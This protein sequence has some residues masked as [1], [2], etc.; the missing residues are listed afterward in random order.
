MTL[1]AIA[2]GDLRRGV[3][4]RRA[5]AHRTAGH[6]AERR[7]AGDHDGAARCWCRCCCAGRPGRRPTLPERP[8]AGAGG[9][10]CPGA[11]WSSSAVDG[12]SLDHISL[13]VAQGRLPNF[14]RVLD[15]GV[16]TPPGDPAADA[17]RTDLDDGGHRPAAAD[18]RGALR[19]AIPRPRRRPGARRAARLHVRPGARPLRVP[20]R[21]AARP[22]GPRRQAAVADP[23]RARHARRAGRAGR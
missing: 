19:G 22:R 4:D 20:A 15:T 1:A 16:A 17:G 5:G 21:G 13:A 3:P 14:G 10:R 11:A 2:V 9:R 8:A 23:Q 12:A 6:G 18:Q 7:A